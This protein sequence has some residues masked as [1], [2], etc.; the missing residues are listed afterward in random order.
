[1]ISTY[2]TAVNSPMV[3]IEECAG[4]S[5]E[6]LVDKGFSDREAAE[7][8]RL[9]DTYFGRTS[10]RAKQRTARRTTLPLDALKI[11]EHYAQKMKTQRAAWALREELCALRV[12]TSEIEKRARRLVRE[13]RSTKR[14]EGVRLTRRRDDLWTLTIT[15][16][17]ELV[18]E[19]NNH[20]STVADARRV[21]SQ[22]AAASTI[23]TNVV[24]TLNEMVKV[25]H[26]EDV[27]LQLTNGAQITGAELAQRALA[28]EGF[29]T[30]LH[31][32]EGPVN[33]YRMR[34]GAT[35][36]QFMMAA[37]ENP[38]CP[39]KGCNK[40]ADECQVHHIF[41]WAGGGWTNA[42]NLTTACA[43][44]NG[45]NDD[46]RTGPPRNGRFERTSRGVRW[47]NPWDPP[48]PDLV[49]TGPTT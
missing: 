13:E 22:G 11:I 43:Y 48:P 9:A 8:A 28:E 14:S 34:R 42:K 21:F 1:M 25:I 15:A 39:V 18:A 16:E 44:H 31:P 45:R 17:S 41:S 32:V 7:F 33:L 40:P 36:K 30:L 35:W 20:V 19:I 5:V 38:T 6:E 47:V 23:T 26:G 37:A 12:A 4:L 2:L 10:F 27:T 24:L 29:V 3:L 46:H 49:E